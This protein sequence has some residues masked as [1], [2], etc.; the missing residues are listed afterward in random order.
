MM[1]YT[2]STFKPRRK[3]KVKKV[4]KAKKPKREFRELTI[5]PT[6]PVSSTDKFKSLDI[7]AIPATMAVPLKYEGEMA[8]REQVAQ[9][10]IARK[11]KMTAPLANKMGYQY[12]GDMPADVIKTLGR[13]V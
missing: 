9:K 5:L 10:E 2:Q 7:A 8:E 1:I 13:K 6:R 11:K 12:I 3:S 4:T